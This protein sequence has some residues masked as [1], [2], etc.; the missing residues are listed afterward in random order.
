VTTTLAGVFV[1]VTLRM[2]LD[3]MLLAQAI[4]ALGVIPLAAWAAS[5]DLRPVF[6]RALAAKVIHFGYPF[7][8]ASLGFWLF[9]SIDRWMLA[10]MASVEEV[11]IYSVAYRY[12]SIVMFVSVAFGLAWSPFAI[13]LKADHPVGY[14][15]F[16]SD[17]LL[18][19]S[20]VMLALGGMIS[21]LAEDLIALLMPSN[22]SAA[23]QPL[24]VL[25]LGVVLQST[26]QVTAI[27][28]SLEKRTHLF[29][30]LSW[31][32]AAINFALNLVLIPGWG[33]LGAAWASVVSYLFLTGSY[34]YY[35]QRLHPLPLPG[36][37]LGLWALLWLGLAAYAS[38]ALILP[39]WEPSLGAKLM[40]LLLLLAGCAALT[41]WWNSLYVK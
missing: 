24:A 14:R 30:R 21:L 10:T 19:L 38:H 37:R 11:G 16:Y 36:R 12:A 15:K 1:V 7:I 18:V 34:L 17:V 5:R 23:A 6:D 13:K 41:P 31:L 32:A 29:G 3:A 35:T 8:Y 26:M 33:A 25:C 39:A 40:L 22:Y 9:G 2:G 28:I 27:G 4:V 20:C